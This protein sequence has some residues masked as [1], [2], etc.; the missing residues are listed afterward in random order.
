MSRSSNEKEHVLNNECGWPISSAALQTFPRDLHLA[1]AAAFSTIRFRKAPWDTLKTATQ[2]R[3]KTFSTN[4]SE[5]VKKGRHS[6]YDHI[7]SQH[8]R[9][10]RTPFNGQQKSQSSHK[11]SEANIQAAESNSSWLYITKVVFCFHHLLC[12]DNTITCATSSDHFVC[13]S[14][15]EHLK[16]LYI[17]ERVHLKAW[18]AFAI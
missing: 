16:S 12:C 5:A 9:C 3:D 18:R 10:Y 1:E 14:P 11:T 15:H 7:M 4:E 6:M 2:N 8:F 13:W 17:E